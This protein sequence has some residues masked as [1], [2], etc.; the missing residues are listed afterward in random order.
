MR[1]FALP[2]NS[3]RFHHS[4]V[5]FLRKDDFHSTP[6][7]SIDGRFQPNMPEAASW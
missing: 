5:R 6:N 1:I 3:S 7:P 2:K 4:I